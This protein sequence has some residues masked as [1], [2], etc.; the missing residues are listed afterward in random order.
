MERKVFAILIHREVSRVKS[1]APPQS[2]VHG[3]AQRRS[4]LAGPKYDP[5]SLASWDREM[6]LP[7]DV[8]Q[9]FTSHII[10]QARFGRE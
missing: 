10:P 8:D 6:Q 4:S 3:N 2:G 7:H 1:N 5:K 9:S